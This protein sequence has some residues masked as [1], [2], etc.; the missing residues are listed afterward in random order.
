MVQTEQQH[1]CELRGVSKSAPAI[2][3]GAMD[4]TTPLSESGSLQSSDTPMACASERRASVSDICGRKSTQDDYLRQLGGTEPRPA[5]LV[6]QRRQP[7]G[8]PRAVGGCALLASTSSVKLFTGPS[9]T[10]IS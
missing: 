7:L 1:R 4:E 2:A 8:E 5:R 9:A 10:G 3:T 6:P